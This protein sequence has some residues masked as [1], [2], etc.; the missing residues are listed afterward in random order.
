M[1]R[2]KK[3]SESLC[4]H[5]L[6]L[7]TLCFGLCFGVVFG[8]FFLS[9]KTFVYQGDSY[10]Q[11]YPSFLYYGE[12]LREMFS[13]LLAGKG[14][15]FPQWEYSIGLGV[16]VFSTLSYY[17]I[18]E[19]LA[20]LS[21]LFPASL[22]PYGYSLMIA[23]RLYLAGLAFCAFL[24]E[25]DCGAL[26][27]ALA[28]VAYVFSGYGLRP[29]IFHSAFSIPMLDFPLL[30]L[31]VERLYRKKDGRL[32]LLAVFHSAVSS[33]YFFYMLVILVIL[34]ALLRYASLFWGEP[35]RCLGQWVLR[36]FLTA[37]AGTALAAPVLLPC[38]SSMLQSERLMAVEQDLLR[39]SEAY[40]THYAA[41]LLSVYEYSYFYV[42][43]SGPILVCALFALTAPR[44]Q[45]REEKLAGAVLFLFTL[46]PFFGSM[47]NGFS[48]VTNRW[49]WAFIAGICFCAARGF[50]QLGRLSPKQL[51]L[52]GGLLVLLT[53]LSLVPQ[54]VESTWLQLAFLWGTYLLAL[55]YA[56]G[57][58]K[59]LARWQPRV[60]ALLTAAGILV[61]GCGLF[62]PGDTENFT[63]YMS[64]TQANVKRLGPVEPIFERVVEDKNCRTDSSP[65]QPYNRALLSGHGTM[66]A[67]FSMI[68]SGT[69]QFQGA[70][71]YNRSCGQQYQ[72]PRWQSMLMSL[73][74][75][76]YYAVEAGRTDELPYGFRTLAAEEGGYAIYKNDYALPLVTLYD[77][78]ASPE[79]ADSPFALQQLML[80]AAVT[81]EE[82]SLPHAG[83]ELTVEEIPFT[84]RQETSQD[85]WMEEGLIQVEKDK[86]TAELVFEP[87]EGKELCLVFDGLESDTERP[88]IGMLTCS[89]SCGTVTNVLKAARPVNRFYCGYQDFLISLGYQPEEQSTIRLRFD[90]AGDYSFDSLKLYGVD[91]AFLEDAAAKLRDSGAGAIQRETNRISFSTSRE[92]PSM[93]FISIPYSENW[94][95]S[96]DGEPAPLRR[97]Q[98]G[99][100]GVELPGGEHQVVMTYRCRPFWL[101]AAVSGAAAV[102]L[103]ALW[104]LKK[105]RAGFCG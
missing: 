11:H 57:R 72:G 73:L 105:R 80:Q 87:V 67:Y 40:Y 54:P 49:I 29:G 59:A 92:S 99:L 63:G 41:G 102:I 26:A 48:Y 51:G 71:Y 5:P 25:R 47:F 1:E 45:F 62:W 82:T 23:L 7:Y 91:S 37:L 100:C 69:T 35:L 98:C 66:S 75:V 55:L 17:I 83:T 101:G 104:V 90:W 19:P 94:S 65:S 58:K 46:V 84:W 50:C 15:V 96:I 36:F 38:L 14:L 74:G 3:W 77:G 33:F 85:V 16:D 31:G 81:E 42:A 103:L 89:A 53:A 39:Y 95:V 24:K 21:A 86:G 18:G 60:T 8:P 9:H 52:T 97:I 6:W 13:G 20:L 79:E 32:F 30:L 68:D 27:G 70:M 64:R 28:A 78:V 10:L 4:R 76:G 56:L 12:K 93:A 22:A 88:G 44:G 43:L 2:V 34:Y 61:T